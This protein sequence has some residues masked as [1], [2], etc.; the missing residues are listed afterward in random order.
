LLI[1]DPFIIIDAILFAALMVAFVRLARRM[2]FPAWGGTALA[3]L[4][5]LGQAR[6]ARTWLDPWT[7]TLSATIIWWL[8]ERTIV[9]AFP[10]IDEPASPNRQ[11]LVFYGCLLCALPLTRPADLVIGAVC[12]SV[13]AVALVRRRAWSWPDIAS[14]VAG[15]LLVLIPYVAL[16]LAIY[17]PRPSPYMVAAAATGFVFSDLPWKTYT[18]LISARP[19]YPD[20]KS[21]IEMAPWLVPAAAGTLSILV[22]RGPKRDVALVVLA[23]A[24]PYSLLLF[25]YVDLQPTGLWDFGNFHYFKWTL[26]F[27]GVTLWHWLTLFRTTRGAKIALATLAAVLAPTCLKVLPQQIDEHE[28]AR[29]LQFRGVTGR[30]W[31]DG[32]FA[33]AEIKDSL[34][35][36]FNVGNFHQIPDATGERAIAITRLFAQRPL[37]NDPGE[38]APLARNERP[39]SRYGARVS[40]GIP[41][42]AK[43]STC[44]LLPSG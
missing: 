31:V 4:A 27:A 25:V 13:L 36:M 37:R 12:L 41:C 33:S 23:V 43:P 35:A 39:F 5:C 15:A 24:M 14:L 11:S 6:A 34:G 22:T 19:W 42:W 18:L 8:I 21:I 9:M 20:T 10:R 32:Y 2:G 38:A 30:P 7:T 16:H 44:R 3:L 40:I 17:G 29:M 28:P 1:A 26:P